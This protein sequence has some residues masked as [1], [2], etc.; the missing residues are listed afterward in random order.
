MRGERNACIVA[1]LLLGEGAY[2]LSDIETGEDV[3]PIML[4]STPEALDEWLREHLGIPGEGL[5]QYIGE[6]RIAV[7]DAL[8]SVVIGRRDVYEAALAR[9]PE[10]EHGRFGEEWHD[11]HRSS[12]NDIGTRAQALAENLRAKEPLND[13]P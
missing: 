5:G 8:A 13:T 1:G 10:A 2:T 4:V 11:K 3:L 7:A 9:I 12:L 6:H